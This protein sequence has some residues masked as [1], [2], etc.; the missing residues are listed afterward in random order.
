[1]SQTELNN[2]RKVPVA[3]ESLFMKRVDYRTFLFKNLPIPVLFQ[4]QIKL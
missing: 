2:D 1:M 4:H 3:Y